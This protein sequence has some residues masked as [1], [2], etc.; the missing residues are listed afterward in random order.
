MYQM[1]YPNYA[2]YLK[3]YTLHNVNLLNIHLPLISRNLR[4]QTFLVEI[5]LLVHISLLYIMVSNIKINHQRI[6]T[7]RCHHYNYFFYYKS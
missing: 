2:T 6:L 3:H 7:T 1:E 4:D 5:S